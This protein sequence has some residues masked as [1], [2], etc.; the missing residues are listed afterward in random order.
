MV[1][2]FKKEETLAVR[3]DKNEID[4]LRSGLAEWGGPAHATDDLAVAMGFE[5]AAD[6]YTQVHRLEEVLSDS[7]ALTAVDW[8]RALVATEVAFVSNN[9]SR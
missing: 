2:P 5:D 1:P 3:L 7:K 8:K 4:L 6:L 9:S